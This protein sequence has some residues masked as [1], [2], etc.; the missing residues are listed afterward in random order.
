MSFRRI[1]ALTAGALLLVLGAAGWWAY[2][3]LGALVKRAVETVG[4]TVTGTPVT[5][6]AAT[7]SVFSGE[8]ALLGLDIAS[9]SGFSGGNAF[10]LG[11]VALSLEPGSLARKLVHVRSIVLDQPE[12]LAET[13]AAGNINLKMLLDHARGGRAAGDGESGGDSGEA[14]RIVID[15]FVCSAAKVRVLAPALKLDRAVTLDTIRLRGIGG[16]QGATP[17]QAA[18]QM[19]RP[20]LDAAL[21]AALREV[22][23]SRRGDIEKRAGEELEKLFRK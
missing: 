23:A 11:R 3:H 12:L 17:G 9:P 6:T 13:D 8:G 15:E 19:L 2:G 7:V 22:I 14:R 21:Q 10:H 4:P 16:R 1:L 5:L 20:V 18:Q